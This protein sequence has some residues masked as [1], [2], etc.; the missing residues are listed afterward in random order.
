VGELP[1]LSAGSAVVVRSTAE[2][3]RSHLDYRPQL[4]RD[5]WYSCAYCTMSEVEASGIGFDIDHYLPLSVRPDLGKDYTNLYYSCRHCNRNKSAFVPSEKHAAL[6]IIRIDREHPRD[7]LIEEDKDPTLLRHLTAT[8]AFNI[9]QLSL[10]RD[11][12]VRLRA[13]RGRLT[14]A[15]GSITFGVADILARGL[16]AVSR[17]H[18]G[19]LAKLHHRARGLAKQSQAETAGFIRECLQSPLLVE[20]DAPRERLRYLR[21][22][23]VLLPG[24]AAR[25]DPAPQQR[26]RRRRRSKHR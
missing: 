23:G 24:E 4:R 11:G 10:N 14:K 15:R 25:I 6:V 9:D 1:Q 20:Q 21:E 12:L 16:D 17:E 7:H 8:G 19:I 26:K 18:K 13:I 22:E 2:P 3:A 5:F